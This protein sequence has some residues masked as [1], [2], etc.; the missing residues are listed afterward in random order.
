MTRRRF[1]GLVP[2]LA[3]VVAGCGQSTTG[4]V[5][6]KWGR[7]TCDYCGMVIGEPRFA[8]QLRAGTNHKVYKFDDLG[9]A[10]LFLVKQ[11]WA[12]HPATEFWVG[13]MET[14]AWIDGFK[15]FYKGGQ[16]T[17][18]A[19]GFGALPAAADG[20]LEYDRFKGAIVVRGSTSRC[21]TGAVQ[22]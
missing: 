19:H 6:V 17:P 22:G 9:D 10:I 2:G 5:E 14:G 1:V 7:D 16:R 13:H 3:L 8:A 4:P 20:L 18:M 21:E 15:A 11:D 12:A